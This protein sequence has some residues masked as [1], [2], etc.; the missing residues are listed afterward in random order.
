M[1]SLLANFHLQQLKNCEKQQH[2][3][4]KK[5]FLIFFSP[6]KFFLETLNFERNSTVTYQ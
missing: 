1:T 2:Q 3:Q 5:F 4:K 6:T